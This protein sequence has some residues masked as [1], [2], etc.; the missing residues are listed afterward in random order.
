MSVTSIND[1]Q[2]D[3]L[4]NSEFSVVKYYASWCGSCRLFAPKF[5]RLAEDEK[6]RNIRFLEID[7]ENNPELR[8]I[9]NVGSLPYFAIFKNGV[10]KNG[11]STAKEDSLI[12]LIEENK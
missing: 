5:K 1:K 9:A 10:F 12:K 11:V 2:K 8:K 6:F 4:N 3:L 7:A